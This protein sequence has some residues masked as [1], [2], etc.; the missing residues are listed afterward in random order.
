MNCQ[1]AKRNISRWLD[2]EL[3]NE[4]GRNLAAHIETCVFCREEAAVFRAV[5]GVLRSAK[6]NI[7]ASPGFETVFWKRVSDRQGIPWVTRLLNNLE[8]L[9]PVPNLRQAVAFSILAFFIGNIGGAAA[10]VG[11]GAFAA[12]PPSSIRHFS[13]LQEFKGISPYSFT[14]MYL[15]TIEKEVSG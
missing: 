8:A 13:S 10:K 14:A 9:V 6:E 4:E 7:Q 3:E 15:K 12:G 5:N 1:K 11:Q 2:G